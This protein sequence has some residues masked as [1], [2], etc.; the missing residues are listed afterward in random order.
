[1]NTILRV[2]IVDENK[3]G[4]DVPLVHFFDDNTVMVVHMKQFIRL[5]LDKVRFSRFNT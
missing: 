1:M 3:Q 4:H 2:E 5:P